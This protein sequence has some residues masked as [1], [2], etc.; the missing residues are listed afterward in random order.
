MD[1]ILEL[2]CLHQKMIL[3]NLI[4]LKKFKTSLL[5]LYQ[6]WKRFLLI[7][8]W[9]GWN[10]LFTYYVKKEPLYQELLIEIGSVEKINHVLAI[11][12]KYGIKVTMF[13]WRKIVRDLQYD[14]DGPSYAISCKSEISNLRK[15][16][17]SYNILLSPDAEEIITSNGNISKVSSIVN[18]EEKSII[19]FMG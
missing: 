2:T 5:L 8:K 18:N 10:T 12:Q 9:R 16:M 15:K 4:S 13:D 14:S 17:A 1:T 3:I 6:V 11:L 7:F 19:Y